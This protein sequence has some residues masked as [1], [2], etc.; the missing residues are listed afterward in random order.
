MHKARVNDRQH[1]LLSLSVSGLE[2]LMVGE[3][4]LDLSD[5]FLVRVFSQKT[6]PHFVP[7]VDQKP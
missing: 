7:T 2:P 4:Q 6:V 5:V 1:N 3:W